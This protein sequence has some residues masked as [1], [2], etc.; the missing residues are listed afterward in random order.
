M[1]AY[2]VATCLAAFIVGYIAAHCDGR[3]EK[4]MRTNRP[5]NHSG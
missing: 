2:M 3:M 4:P 1:D 5:K